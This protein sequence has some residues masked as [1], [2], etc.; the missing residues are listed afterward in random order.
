MGEERN[1]HRAE[2]ND[3][4]HQVEGARDNGQYG[5]KL[6]GHRRGSFVLVI[7]SRRVAQTARSGRS[8]S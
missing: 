8:H 7:K 6:L 2:H 5:M 3:H 4:Q 1:S